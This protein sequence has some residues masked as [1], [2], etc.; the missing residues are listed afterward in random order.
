MQCQI[1]QDFTAVQYPAYLYL[2][3]RTVQYPLDMQLLLSCLT[4]EIF[5]GT[6]PHH[7]AGLQAEPDLSV[8]GPCEV[9]A[10]VALGTLPQWN[11]ATVRAHGHWV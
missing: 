7:L 11:L 6:P 1:P 4:G 10:A 3:P 9:A 2:Y 8:G 5:L